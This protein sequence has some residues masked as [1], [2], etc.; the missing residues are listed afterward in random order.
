VWSRDTAEGGRDWGGG[1]GGQGVAARHGD[2]PF[3]ASSPIFEGSFDHLLKSKISLV[4][5]ARKNTHNGF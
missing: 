2:G 5:C 1:R 4:L 3:N